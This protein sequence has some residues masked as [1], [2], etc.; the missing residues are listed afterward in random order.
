MSELSLFALG[1]LDEIGKNMYAIDIDGR[2]YL[3]EAGLKYPESKHLGVE[4]IIQ[5]FKYLIDNKNRIQGIFITHAHDDTFGALPY[6]LKQ[7]NIPIYS[8]PLILLMIKKMLDDQGI[9]NAQFHKLP[10]FGTVNVGGTDV[11]TFGLTHA[12]PDAFGVSFATK[13]G[14]IVLADEFIIDFDARES[15]FDCDL[16]TIAEIGKKG[17]LCLMMESSYADHPGYTA[18]NHRISNLIRPIFEDTKGRIIVSVYNQNYYRILE[19]IRMAN[20]FKR[21]VFFYDDNIKDL[22]RMNEQ[23]NYYR[24]PLGLEIPRSKFNNDDDDIVILV[25]GT[26]SGLFA[27]MNKIDTN[28]DSTIE[29]RSSDTVIIASPVAPGTEHEATAMINELYKE[30]V[31][32]EQ[33]SAKDV[34]A[35]HPSVEDLKIM[36][37]LLKPK[38]CLPIMGEYR[39]F[40]T[41]AN[42]ALEAGYT[43]DKVIILDNGQVARFKAG[44]LTSC[45]EHYDFGETMIDGKDNLDV[46]GFVLKDRE[47][48]STDGVIVVGI[49]LNFK[50]KEIIGGPD[51][52]SRGV[53]Y[54]KDSEYIIKNIG[55]IIKDVITE[56]VKD[57]SY[58]NNGARLEAR[59]RIAKY[60]LKE[61][62]KRPMILPAIIEINVPAEGG[63]ANA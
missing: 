63:K 14:S 46:T 28:E 27:A 9:V 48:L 35:V 59:E 33:L 43:P 26:G 36:L 53:I 4:V 12:C 58:D 57:G 21:H 13:N 50:N 37:Y 16:G 11:T 1:G 60:V 29:L 5:D 52:Q 19:I 41:A 8:T 51:I 32:V 3:V 49:S 2:L 17:V 31:D 54:I 23:L 20:E 22:I 38:Y 42:I 45:S 10:R 7:V 30:N 39:H 56:K 15:G 6:L 61:T 62:G 25:T 18:P 24:I 44:N 34:L 40:M 47:T 55:K